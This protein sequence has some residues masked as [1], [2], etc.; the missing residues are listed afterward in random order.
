MRHCQR[1]IS[2]QRDTEFQD[3]GR[4]LWWPGLDPRVLV[5]KTLPT[6]AHNLGLVMSR[7]HSLR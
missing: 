6:V 4:R 3:S 1:I 2:F 7:E 5:A